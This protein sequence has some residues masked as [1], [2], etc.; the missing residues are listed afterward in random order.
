MMSTVLWNIDSLKTETARNS[1]KSVQI[2]HKRG[3]MS[4]KNVTSLPT[5]FISIYFQRYQN[6]LMIQTRVLLIPYFHLFL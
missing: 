2:A 1:E 6:F 4:Q 5:L 3:I